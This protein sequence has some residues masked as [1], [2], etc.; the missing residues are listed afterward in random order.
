MLQKIV[1]PENFTFDQ[2]AAVY[3]LRTYGNERYPGAGA[4]RLV[5]IPENIKPTAKK[6]SEW[7]KDGYFIGFKEGVSE[8]LEAIANLNIEKHE[9][10]RNLVR[11]I[12]EYNLGRH[13]S[14]G[15]FP[16]ILEQYKK[17]KPAEEAFKI[18]LDQFE[19]MQTAQSAWLTEIAQ[20]F[21]KSC[22]IFKIK[23][24][25]SKVK[26]V[27]CVSD[28]P[29]MEQYLVER[30]FASAILKNSAG[31]VK[32]LF[33]GRLRLRIDEFVAAL[34]ML[35]LM[36]AGETMAFVNRKKFHKPGML[37]EDGV[38]DFESKNWRI[39]NS[40][41]APKTKIPLE[42]IVDLLKFWLSAEYDER[43]CAKSK[44]LY[45]PLVLD[46][47]KRKFA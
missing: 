44:C 20:E 47:C 10:L 16:A 24:R 32:I 46:K 15:T 30:K 31:Y 36:A 45:Y 8:S 14:F 5:F 29:Q 28:H 33:N 2:L 7:Q 17:I 12:K 22:S 42:Q 39:V 23:R 3:L 41:S 34:R 4:A 43:C 13:R 1:L 21:A 9:E 35:E 19:A 27:V 25:R 37:R 38:W 6:I 11:F 18:L 26:V 40:A